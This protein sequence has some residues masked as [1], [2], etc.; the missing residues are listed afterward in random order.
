MSNAWGYTGCGGGLVKPAPRNSKREAR[1]GDG[2]RRAL[3]TDI[4]SFWKAVSSGEQRPGAEGDD[5][6][7]EV[8]AR[9]NGTV[10]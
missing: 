6:V 7:G 2:L 8:I 4:K 5:A 9:Q 1:G 10:R 3:E